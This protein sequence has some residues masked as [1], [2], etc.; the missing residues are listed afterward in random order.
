MK[1]FNTVTEVTEHINQLK[2]NDKKIGLIPTMGALH[3]GHMS[4]IDTAKE[5]TDCVVV[6]I[7]VNPKQFN[8]PSDLEG[9][10]RTVEQD[11]KILE[12]QGCDIV[13]CPNESAI[14]PKNYQLLPLQLGFLDES[15][16]GKYR[17][18][19]FVGVVNVVHRLFE[20]VQP[21]KAFFG[22][23]DFQQVAVIKF[24]VDEFN[25]PVEVVSCE[26]YREKS[27]LAFSS[28]NMRLTEKQK[29]DAKIIYETLSRGRKLALTHTPEETS[30]KMKSHLNNDGKLELE[31]L[32]IV[33][34]KNLRPLKQ[35]WVPGATAC[36][37]A[38][39]GEIRLIDNLQ[40]TDEK[41]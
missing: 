11:L 19:H 4:L 21:D 41:V 32:E 18:G 6:S 17:P 8:N 33:D 16:E 25:L 37:A 38:Y 29:G 9:Y 10:P 35:D 12:N 27:G 1:V 5:Q 13:F 7:F 22:R 14:Y 36:I 20:I 24:M 39:C 3:K 26:T 31:Y 30:K 15:M 28:R 2:N 34:P 40:L 23:K